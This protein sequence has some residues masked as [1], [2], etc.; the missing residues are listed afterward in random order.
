MR[1]CTADSQGN[2]CGNGPRRILAG[3]TM[4]A[5]EG[6]RP[7]R[8]VAARDLL[9]TPRF[10]SMVLIN[11]ARRVWHV[12]R[13][14]VVLCDYK[15]NTRS[16]ESGSR[17]AVQ[18]ACNQARSHWRTRPV[19]VLYHSQAAWTCGARHQ[20][21][22]VRKRHVSAGPLPQAD[23]VAVDKPLVARRSRN[24]S[25]RRWQRVRVSQAYAELLLW[26]NI[27]EPQ[28]RQQPRKRNVCGNP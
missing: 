5:I 8:D 1:K 10:L 19:A 21:T 28:W 3:A 12:G 7:A 18:P 27:S 4:G 11:P 23:S 9:I 20:S 13:Q 14:G 6:H 2:G 22:P 17:R 24:G 15:A 25:D 16:T 26:R